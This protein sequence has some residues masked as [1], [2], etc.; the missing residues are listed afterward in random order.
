[1]PPFP[2]WA[3]KPQV[4]TLTA[5]LG[6]PHCAVGY[7]MADEQLILDAAATC[8]DLLEVIEPSAAAG[9]VEWLYKAPQVW[10]GHTLLETTGRAP[11]SPTRLRRRDPV[12]GGGDAYRGV[13]AR[14]G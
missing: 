10:L 3:A 11:L 5:C 7:S 2:G 8:D 14:R 1:M 12:P 9:E 4:E 13:A 6:G